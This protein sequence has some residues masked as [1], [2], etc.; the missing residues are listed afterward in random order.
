MLIFATTTERSTLTQL[1]LFNRFDAE[2]PVPNVNSQ[3][4]L[5]TILTKTG[6]FGERDAARA[7]EEIQYS[8][9]STDIGVGIKKVLTGI[10]TAKQDEDMPGR[11]AR[12]VSTAIQAQRVV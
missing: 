4:E 2:I 3:Q 6:A 10:E 1:D 8:T 7:I 5:A 9:G 12:V 11:F